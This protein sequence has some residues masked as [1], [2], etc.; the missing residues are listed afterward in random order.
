MSFLQIMDR[1]TERGSG[2]PNLSL[3]LSPLQES[4]QAIVTGRKRKNIFISLP[5]VAEEGFQTQKEGAEI[6]VDLCPLNA[7]PCGLIGN[8]VCALLVR[9]QRQYVPSSVLI[10]CHPPDAP[11][12]EHD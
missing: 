9:L 6:A 1:A 8:T 4:C 7:C 12:A 3:A 11:A 10:E 5:F 2:R